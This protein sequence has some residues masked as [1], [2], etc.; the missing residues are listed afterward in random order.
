MTFEESVSSLRALVALERR[1]CVRDE[2]QIYRGFRRTNLGIVRCTV[3]GNIQTFRA[4]CYQV[5]H[6]VIQL[7]QLFEMNSLHDAGL[8]SLPSQL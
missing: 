5:L 3:D 7:V 2:C 6:N 4:L 1:D 8:R